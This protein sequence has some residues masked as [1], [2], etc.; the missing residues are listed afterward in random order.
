M[1][2]LKR[3]V[4]V[5]FFEAIILCI[6]ASFQFVDIQ[7]TVILLIFNVLFLSIAFQL[8]GTFNKKLAL[9]LLGNITG[10][11]W[12]YTFH[13]FS[14]SA[15]SSYENFSALYT[16]IYPILN[17]LWVICFWSLSLAALQRHDNISGKLN[18]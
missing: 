5:L 2:I 10:L 4:T 7:S 17:S 16:I 11:F 13:F 3:L 14:I 1:Q 12:N 8:K 6:I 9:L 15:M 18:F